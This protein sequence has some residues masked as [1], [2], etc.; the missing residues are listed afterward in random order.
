MRGLLLVV[1]LTFIDHSSSFGGDDKFLRK[2]A[3]MK[4]YE[5][6]FGQEVVKEVRM[7][8][9]AAA[10][11]C[12]GSGNGIQLGGAASHQTTNP[13][14]N[15]IKQGIVTST[16]HKIHHQKPHHSALV[17][18]HES[19]PEAAALHSD[20][21]HQQQPNKQPTLDLAKLQ[22]AIMAGYNNKQSYT[23]QTF[24]SS[25]HHQPGFAQQPHYQLGFSSRPYYQAAQPMPY[26]PPQHAPYPQPPQ[27]Y[28]PSPYYQQ[29]YQPYQPYYGRSSR[30]LDVRGQLETLTTRMSGRIRNVTCVMQE[31]GYLDNNLEPDYSRMIDR[32]ARLPVAD[33][34]KKDM[35]E[36][37]DFCRQFSQCVPDDRKDKLIREMVRPMFFFRCY[38]HKKLEACI[39][40]D[41]RERYTNTD[42]LTEDNLTGND[43][44][45]AKEF[46]EDNM[47]TA[48]Y[49]FLYGGDNIDIDTL[50]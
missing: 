10:S 44:R 40:K 19:L 25:N 17:S 18:S 50:L 37:V 31:L 29:A 34:L 32:I 43:N 3:M 24:S 30:D 26:Y 33:D 21:Q 16:M 22:E 39:M 15:Q 42:D 4:V 28:M 45:V 9:K 1:C 7:E 38:K 48:I 12:A 46:S 13:Q 20:G 27:P 2:Y 11:K 47:A 6:C 8:M 35:T 49:E 23:Q 36:G 41:V 5:S 14:H